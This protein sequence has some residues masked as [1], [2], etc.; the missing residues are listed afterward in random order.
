MA[1]SRVERGVNSGF[2]VEG[3]LPVV[4][5]QSLVNLLFHSPFPFDN[6]SLA[7]FTMSEHNSPSAESKPKPA[8]GESP[9]LQ[10][11]I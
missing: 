10:A 6:Q 1:I 4:G 5:N 9:N 7:L 11:A 3:T 2:G 8:D